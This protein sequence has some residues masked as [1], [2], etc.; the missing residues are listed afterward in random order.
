MCMQIFQ[1]KLKDTQAIIS[2]NA[3]DIIGSA[4]KVWFYKE[5]FYGITKT[6]I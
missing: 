4:V 1:V 2:V 3:S 5:L 6:A